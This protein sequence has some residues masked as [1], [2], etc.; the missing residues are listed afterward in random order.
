[1]SRF[2]V[3]AVLLF[4]VVPSSFARIHD[5][6]H[7]KKL[8]IQIFAMGFVG[9]VVS[10]LQDEEVDGRPVYTVPLRF[11]EAYLQTCDELDRHPE[12]WGVPSRVA[13]RSVA[14]IL[15]KNRQ[16]RENRHDSFDTSDTNA[17]V[18]P[19]RLP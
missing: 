15:W 7:S 16:N 2:V 5:D 6:C 13:I 1:M 8:K 10:V 12:L 14:D 18:I 9:G 3:L 11:S 17:L 19:K 4:L